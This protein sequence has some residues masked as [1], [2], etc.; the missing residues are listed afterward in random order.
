MSTG[1]QSAQSTQSSLTRFDA[2]AAVAAEYPQEPIV[3]ALGTMVREMLLATGRRENHLY[4]LD[5]MGLP[6]AI[7][8]GVALSPAARHYDKVITI[9]GDG[10]LLMGFSTLATIGL[11]KPEKLLLIVLDNGAYA[12]TGMQRTAAPAIDLCAAAVSCGIAAFDVSTPDD[13]QAVLRGARGVP[14]PTLVR[15]VIGAENRQAPYFLPD[16]VEITLS[17]QRYLAGHAAAGA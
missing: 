16:P 11:L 3:V 2:L 13:L 10:G 7:G 8:L 1:S 6:A 9:E 12:A 4:V 17:F 14:G 5:S 15:V